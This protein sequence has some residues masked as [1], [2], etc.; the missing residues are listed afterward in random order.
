MLFPESW[1]LTRK[2]TTGSA[3]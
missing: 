2:Q 3:I 1:L